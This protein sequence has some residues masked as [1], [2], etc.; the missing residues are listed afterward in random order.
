[1]ELFACNSFRG[2]VAQRGERTPSRVEIADSRAR[3]FVLDKESR[4]ERFH[5]QSIK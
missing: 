4:T 2:L 1:M 5:L 3:M